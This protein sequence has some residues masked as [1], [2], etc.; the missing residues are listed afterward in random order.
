M[1]VPISIGVMIGTTKFLLKV[2]LK[3]LVSM[4]IFVCGDSE[5]NFKPVLII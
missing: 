4:K 1:H 3:Q 2:I 5:A